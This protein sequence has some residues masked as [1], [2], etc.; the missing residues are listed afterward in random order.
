MKR[1]EFVGMLAA[2]CPVTVVIGSQGMV[3]RTP[4]MEDNPGVDGHWWW[5]DGAPPDAVVVEFDEF[6]ER[7]MQ[8][9]ADG[10]GVSFD[11]LTEGMV[12]RQ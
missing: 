9:I 5:M 8:E 11:A 10:L 3:S 2:L 6:F 7:M 1:R 4:R 12:G